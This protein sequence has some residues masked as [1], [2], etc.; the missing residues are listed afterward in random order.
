MNEL[1]KLD[2]DRLSP[3]YKAEYEKRKTLW[4]RQDREFVLDQLKYFRGLR[5]ALVED[6]RINT[7]PDDVSVAILTGIIQHYIEV[8]TNANRQ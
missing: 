7:D 2:W 4:W 5:A 6:L 1:E 3:M 8:L